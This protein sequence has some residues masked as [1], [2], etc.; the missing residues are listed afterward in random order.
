MFRTFSPLL[1]MG[2]MLRTGVVNIHSQSP[3]FQI[4]DYLAEV[5]DPMRVQPDIISVGNLFEGK[6]I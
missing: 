5:H 4:Y 3:V 2:R 6:M 1:K